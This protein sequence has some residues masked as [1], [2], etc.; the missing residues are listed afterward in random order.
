MKPDPGTPKIN[1]DAC[2]MAD[3]REGATC[4]VIRDHEGH[5]VQGQALWYN[6]AANSLIME[7]QAVRDGVRLAQERHYQNVEIQTDAQEVFNLMQ[8]PGG[9]KSEIAS[10]C[11]E[12]HELSG[13]FSSMKFSFVGRLAN[14]ATYACAKRASAN[15]RRCLWI[16]YTPP[17]L[18]KRL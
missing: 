12:I 18:G 14:E 17:S 6:V 9:G 7:A 13:V 1:V 10:I 5:L 2:F 15:G 16:N 11:Q 4:L 3:T 8:E